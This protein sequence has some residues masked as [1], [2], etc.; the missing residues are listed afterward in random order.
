MNTNDRI[1]ELEAALE[2][3]EPIKSEVKHGFANGYYI[4]TVI[5][6]KAPEGKE[7]Y[8]TSM[9]HDTT[10]GYHVSSGEVEVISEND[11]AQLIKGSYWGITIPNTRRVL[12]IISETTWTTFHKTDILPENDSEEAKEEAAK[13]IGNEILSKRE[14]KLLEGHYVNNEFIP[15]TKEINY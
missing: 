13:K 6:P 14:N 11:G 15:E 12:H 1:D 9:V 10:H 7:H 2:K 8:V 5:M 3:F 4:R